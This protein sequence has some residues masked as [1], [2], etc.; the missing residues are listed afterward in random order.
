MGKYT[1]KITYTTGNSFRSEETYDYLDLTW[2]TLEV[3]KRNL[4]YIKEHWEM[5]SALNSYRMGSPTKEEI[6]EQC[7]DKVW[8]VNNGDAYYSEYCM[9]L[10]VD[11]GNFM[12]QRNFWCGYFE[13][14]IC[15]KIEIDESDM[16]F[17]P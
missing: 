13:D 7:S 6:F 5:Y 2:E 10:E 4:K 15:A 14:L 16:I 1:I 12:Q 11:N 9:K 3:A 17:T 8:F